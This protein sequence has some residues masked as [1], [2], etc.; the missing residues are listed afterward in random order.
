MQLTTVL[1]LAITL[2]AAP[3]SVAAQ[4][5]LAY[6]LGT[7]TPNGQ[8]KTTAD[9]EADFDALKG[10]TDLVRG[11]A[12]DRCN[13]AELALPAAKNKDFKVVLGIWCVVASHR[14]LAT[15]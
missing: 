5:R 14:R 2:V 11:Y 7:E 9:Y 6:A 1:P 4:G 10:Q 8:C 15:G 12:A 3:L 13:F